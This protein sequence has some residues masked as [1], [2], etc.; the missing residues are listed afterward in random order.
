MCSFAEYGFDFTLP[1]LITLS[2]EW[3]VDMVS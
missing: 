1:N 2:A 3:G